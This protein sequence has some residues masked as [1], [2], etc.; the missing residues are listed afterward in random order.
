MPEPCV[1]TSR[2]NRYSPCFVCGFR[3]VHDPTPTTT[4]PECAERKS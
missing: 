4:A 2:H 3:G 1:N